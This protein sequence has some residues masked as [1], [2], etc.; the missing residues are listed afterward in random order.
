MKFLKVL[1]VAALAAAM[2]AGAAACGGDTSE[3]KTE[4]PVNNYSVFPASTYNDTVEVTMGDV[5]PYYDA[6]SGVMNIFHLQN[7]RGSNSNYYH[8]I[9]RL[10]TSD[11]LTYDY[12]GI[13]INF[14]ENIKSPD[15]AI[16]TG[17]F[18]KDEDGLYHCFY[19]GHNA[20]GR[21]NSGLEWIQVVRHA[22]STDLQMWTKIKEFNLYGGRNDFRDP[23]VY[24]DAQDGLYYMLITTND[25]THGGIIKRYSSPS[26]SADDTGWTDCGIFYDDPDAGYN[27]E[28]RSYVEY[29]GY[30]YLAYSEQGEN[31]VTHYRYRTSRDGEWLKFERDSIDASGFYAGRL[32]KAGEELY[33]FAW[34]AT[35]TGGS[36]GEFDWGGNLVTHRLTQGT[37]GELC[38]V[39]VGN[40]LDKVSSEQKVSF[41]DGTPVSQLSFTAEKFRASAVDV[42]IPECV[43]R[44]SFDVTIDGTGGNAGVTFGLRDAYDNRLGSALIAFDTQKGEIAGYNDVSNVLRYGSALARVPFAF[45]DGETYH[46]E[47][48]IDGDV[49]T[50]Y[51][52]NTVAMTVRIV[53]MA[54]NYFSFYSNGVSAAFGGI[55]F[56]V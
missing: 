1:T 32:E 27:M 19:T 23:Y 34:C 16:G 15:A 8:P 55:K 44:V 7:T 51:F 9:A 28:C 36:V 10:T 42:E 43:V 56:Y 39:P 47:L 52:D 35:L 41:T 4:I 29:N 22:T 31:R 40:V 6:D 20:A 5:M 11:F 24:Y 25:D 2:C 14:E 33:A 45:T 3:E 46:V 50:V 26:L 37:N 54:E 21:E 38:A 17:S 18:I 48:L 49:V 12:K 30:W 13:S 53:G